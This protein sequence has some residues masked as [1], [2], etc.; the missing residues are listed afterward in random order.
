LSDDEVE[1]VTEAVH[2]KVPEIKAL[3][4]TKQD[5]LDAGGQGPNPE[6]IS[7]VLRKKLAELGALSDNSDA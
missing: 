1:V 5:I 6:I 7:T 4:V 3:H 2:T